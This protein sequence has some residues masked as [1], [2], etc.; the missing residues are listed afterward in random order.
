MEGARADGRISLGYGS[1]TTGTH[2][3]TTNVASGCVR[4]GTKVWLPL[5]LGLW[6]A[7][8]P[9][10][11]TASAGSCLKGLSCAED[12]QG[13][14]ALDTQSPLSAKCQPG[15]LGSPWAGPRHA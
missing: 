13:A 12:V 7:S 6:L 11:S 5:S 2:C 15:P 4:G 1:R 10:S 14:R 9:R 8:V 3:R